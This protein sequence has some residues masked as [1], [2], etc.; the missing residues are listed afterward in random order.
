LLLLAWTVSAFQRAGTIRQPV[1]LPVDQAPSDSALLR[2][3]NA[4]LE[5]LRAHDFDRAMTFVADDVI[6]ESEKG[7]N[8]PAVKSSLRYSVGNGTLAEE[9]ERALELGGSFTTTRGTVKGERQFCAPYVY[10][11]FPSGFDR[12][13]PR[14]YYPS[15]IIAKNVPVRAGPSFQTRVIRRLS[16]D[17]VY[18]V[19]VGAVKDDSGAEWRRLDGPKGLKGF[20]PAETVRDPEDYHVCFASRPNG[21]QIVDISRNEFPT[22]QDLRR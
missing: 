1:L 7:S 22:L 16:Y 21:W 6:Y 13:E 5:A 9:L 15:V 8:K 10:S 4:L 14:D 18:V 2:V 19:P 20:V 12:L 17:L 3:R 11:A